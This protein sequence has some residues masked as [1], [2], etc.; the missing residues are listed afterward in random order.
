MSVLKK[1]LISSVADAL[2]LTVKDDVCNVLIQ[3]TEYRLR[4]LIYDSVK[5]SF[6][7]KQKMTINSFSSQS[8]FKQTNNLFYLQ[9]Y[10]LD[11]ETVINQPL[12]ASDL[13]CTFTAHWLAI[14]GVQPRIVQNPTVTAPAAKVDAPS[15]SLDTPLVKHVLTLE[16]Q[17]FYDKITRSI[18]SVDKN[19]QD[20]AISSL[21]LGMFFYIET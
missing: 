17:L 1:E 21:S 2:G 11:L 20:L 18:C 13:P 5:L 4:E 10:D 9:D 14:D 16:L 8:T 3:D 6:I 7:S 19:L 15:T 12:P